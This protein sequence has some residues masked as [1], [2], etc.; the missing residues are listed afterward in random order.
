M[1]IPNIGSL[2]PG[3]YGTCIA[4]D[5]FIYTSLL[6]FAAKLARCEIVLRPVSNIYKDLTW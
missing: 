5:S 4:N 1:T 6:M 3:T 2:D